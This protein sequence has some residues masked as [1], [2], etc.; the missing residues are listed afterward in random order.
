MV[1][2]QEAPVSPTGTTGFAGDGGSRLRVVGAAVVLAVVAG[3]IGWGAPQLVAR[4]NQPKYLGQP[5]ASLAR[6]MNCTEFKQ[7]ARHDQSV[8]RYHDQG[9]CTLDG[10]IVTVTTFDSVADGDA[11]AAVM[12]AIIPVL[13][14]TWVGATYAAG[15]GWNVAD[16]RNLTAQAAELAVRRLGMGATH[17]IPSAKSS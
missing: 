11:F 12:R 7:A 5:A 6:D 17:I 2:V 14:P 15:D 10:T 3:L 9:T 8:Y 1:A 16:A 13:H 4:F